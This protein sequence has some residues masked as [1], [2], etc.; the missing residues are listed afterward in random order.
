MVGL[1][2]YIFVAFLSR[3]VV[4][5]Q[6]G[7]DVQANVHVYDELLP[8]EYI[9]RFT[10]KKGVPTIWEDAISLRI[11]NQNSSFRNNN[12]FGAIDMDN[13]N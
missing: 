8:V 3:V 12:P 11:G 1:I 9:D 7:I 13:I 6:A 10:T 5:R 2:K 4:V